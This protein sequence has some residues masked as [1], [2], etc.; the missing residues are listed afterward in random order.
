METHVVVT[1]YAYLI[2]ENCLVFVFSY[3]ALVK[4]LPMFKTAAIVNL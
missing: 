3:M 1:E 4:Y 2:L